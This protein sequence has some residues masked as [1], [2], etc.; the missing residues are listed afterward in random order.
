[1]RQFVTGHTLNGHATISEQVMVQFP[2]WFPYFGERFTSFR[3]SCEEGVGWAMLHSVTD[4]RLL[5]ALLIQ[6]YTTYLPFPSDFGL[7]LA[8]GCRQ[9]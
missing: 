9:M 8:D 7:V 2:D 5:S 1:M 6:D 3:V 4:D